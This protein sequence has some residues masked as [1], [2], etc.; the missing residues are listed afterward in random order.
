M[1]GHN[2]KQGSTGG[3]TSPWCSLPAPVRSTKMLQA[4]LRP[5]ACSRSEGFHVA[6]EHFP[7]LKHPGREAWS[8]RCGI[9]WDWL[10]C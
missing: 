5:H 10:S 1:G 6:W 8:C 9:H 3:W 2:W 4:G 7:G